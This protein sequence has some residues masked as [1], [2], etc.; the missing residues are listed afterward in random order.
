MND[1]K[2]LGQVGVD[3]TPYSFP[4]ADKDAVV[5]LFCEGTDDF[6]GDMEEEDGAN[7]WEWQNDND[8]WVTFHIEAD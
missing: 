6:G 7:E 2:G 3:D 4:Y 5:S 1:V 8:E